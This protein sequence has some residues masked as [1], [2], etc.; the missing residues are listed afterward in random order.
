M[1]KRIINLVRDEEGVT[2]L[3][4]GLIAALIA[5]FIVAAVTALGT[6]VRDTFNNIATAMSSAMGGG[7][8]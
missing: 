6:N 1:V 2:A 7:T 4:Y 8:T 5:A 3:E